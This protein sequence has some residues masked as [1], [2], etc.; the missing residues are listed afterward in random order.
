[1][2]WFISILKGAPASWAISTLAIGNR[3]FRMGRICWT[4]KRGF[5]E[6]MSE[7]WRLLTN[8]SNR[9]NFG[10]WKSSLSNIKMWCLQRSRWARVNWMSRFRNRKIFSALTT[11]E[12][13]PSRYWDFLNVFFL[14]LSFLRPKQPKI[15]IWFSL[16]SMSLWSHEQQSCFWAQNFHR[17]L[18]LY[19]SFKIWMLCPLR[20][21][22]KKRKKVSRLSRFMSFFQLWTTFFLRGKSPCHRGQTELMKVVCNIQMMDF[23]FFFKFCVHLINFFAVFYPRPSPLFQIYFSNQIFTPTSFTFVLNCLAKI[24]LIKFLPHFTSPFLFSRIFSFFNF[25]YFSDIG[26][27][28][29]P[30]FLWLVLFPGECAGYHVSSLHQSNVHPTKLSLWKSKFLHLWNITSKRCLCCK[31]LPRHFEIGFCNIVAENKLEGRC[32]CV[33]NIFTFLPNFWIFF[34]ST[35]FTFHLRE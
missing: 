35:S 10:L 16:K 8:N 28:F 23:G 24:F 9:F 11:N 30:L 26:N 3:C 12:L 19:S 34:L 33:C 6:R 22:S 2:S 32:V 1:M 4:T 20:D 18:L 15:T 21:A 25:S 29:S 31:F 13:N 14:F 27:F 5:S 17:A 7:C